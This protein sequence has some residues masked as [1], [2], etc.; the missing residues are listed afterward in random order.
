M[1]EAKI[2]GNTDLQVVELRGDMADGLLLGGI[3]GHLEKEIIAALAGLD[4]FIDITKR[5]F[6]FIWRS[7][8]LVGC[9]SEGLRL[10]DI[11]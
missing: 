2:W 9:K 6:G 10:R 5:H 8:G 3:I 1:V 11:A 4:A 7:G